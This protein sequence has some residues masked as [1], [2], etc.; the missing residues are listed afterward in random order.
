MAR[1]Q[2]Q[3]KIEEVQMEE[4]GEFR[5]LGSCISKDESTKKEISSWIVLAAAVFRLALDKLDQ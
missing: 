5:Y 1:N 4:A 3:I 2:V